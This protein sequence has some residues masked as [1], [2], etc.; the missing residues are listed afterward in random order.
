[1]DYNK[2]GETYY[3]RLDRGDELIACLRAVC[4]KENILSAV[5]SGIGGCSDAEVQCFLPEEGTFETTRLCG[6]LELVSLH[7]NVISDE[8]D[9]RFFHTHALFSWR[10][11]AGHHTLGG[12]LK[13]TTVRYTA[14]IELRPVTGGTIRR[15]Y[16][17]ETGTGFWK[18]R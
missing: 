16:D 12:H 4:Q 2:F 18:L 11:D 17:A 13:S 6:T 7:G 14:E 3:V 15:A 8:N 5:F 10:D 1:M 9:E